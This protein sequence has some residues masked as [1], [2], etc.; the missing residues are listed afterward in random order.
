MIM[1]KAWVAQWLPLTESSQ[2]ISALLT[3]AGL[4]VDAVCPVASD[5][6]EVVVGEVVSMAA[7]PDAQKLNVCQVNVGR[8]FLQIVCGAKNVCAGIKVPV[9]LVGAVLSHD[10]H[11][12]KTQLRGVDSNGMICSKSE[13][14]ILERFSGASKHVDGHSEGIWVLPKDAPV[15]QDLRDYL[16]LEDESIEIDLTPNRSDCLSIYGLARELSVLTQKPL[17]NLPKMQVPIV[18]SI[19]ENSDFKNLP[20]VH[21]EKE[22]VK[23]YGIR[24]ISNINTNVESPIW[25]QEH[26]R[27]CGIQSVSFIVDVTQYVML[28]IGQPMHAFDANQGIEKEMYVRFAKQGESAVLLDGKTYALTSEDVVIADN[29]SILA[30]AGIMG[31]RDSAISHETTDIILESAEFY[32]AQILKS[33]KQKGLQSESSFRFERGI[34]SDLVAY[35]L[36]YATEVILSYAG[37]EASKIQMYESPEIKEA[38]QKKIVLTRIKIKR[39]LGLALDDDFV[40]TTLVRLGMEV[41]PFESNELNLGWLVSVPK[42]RHD[43]EQAVDLVE[44][45]IRIYGYDQLP[46]S[47]PEMNLSAISVE[48]DILNQESWISGML[49]MGYQQVINYNFISQFLDTLFTQTFTQINSANNGSD[50]SNDSSSVSALSLLNPISEDMSVM[51]RSLLPGLLLNFKHNLARQQQRVFLFESGTVFVSESTDS[52]DSFKNPEEKY[53]IAGL[54]FGSFYH[55]SWRSSQQEKIDFYGVKQ[56]VM[57]LLGMLGC[58]CD[59]SVA[60]NVISVESIQDGMYDFLHPGQSA[61]ILQAGLPVGIIGVIHPLILEKMQIKSKP[62]IVFELDGSKLKLAKSNMIYESIS[63]YPGISRDLSFIL[64][65]NISSDTVIQLIKS[66]NESILKNVYIFD[67]YEGSGDCVLQNNQKSLA[68]SLYFQNRNK[69]LLEDEVNVVIDKIV[70][71]AQNELG[72]QLRDM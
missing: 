72:A 15:G 22:T 66:V 42:F 8:D 50:S 69:T 25:L 47:M 20:T 68:F 71:C 23:R 5:F 67:V 4:E 2:V 38:T 52:S 11:I 40:E 49:S 1:S 35:A 63:K 30:L 56:D 28:L 26:L 60:E 12:Q 37:G 32:A 18:E 16:N 36:D 24:K 17:K 51:R 58:F 43:I 21:V 10:L 57:Q 34:D 27:R 7:H 54:A 9:A 48:H 31:G 39:I 6:S 45:L 62:P 64:D 33:A 3:N 41:M 13:L 14:G 70:V 53:Y 65:K 55:Q 19:I 46:E 59:S 44:E 29:S 61:Q